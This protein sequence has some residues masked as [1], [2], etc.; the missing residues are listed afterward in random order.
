MQ[1]DPI[2]IGVNSHNTISKTPTETDLNTDSKIRQ[3]KVLQH[4]AAEGLALHSQ[5]STVCEVCVY[6]VDLIFRLVQTNWLQPA[7]SP[8]AV[9]VSWHGVVECSRGMR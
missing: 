3:S 1:L 4:H 9:S 2:P 8:T 7:A 6:L 5:A